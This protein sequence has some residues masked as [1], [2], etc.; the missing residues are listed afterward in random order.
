MDSPSVYPLL[1]LKL[2]W[3][4]K[5]LFYLIFVMWLCFRQRTKF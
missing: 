2:S 5:S 4:L 3:E 1:K